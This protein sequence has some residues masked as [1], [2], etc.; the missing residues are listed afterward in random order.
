MNKLWISAG[1]EVQSGKNIQQVKDAIA[2]LV[3]T[4]LTEPGC[5]QFDA[6]QDKETPEHFTLWECWQDEA[7]LKAH[8][9]APHTKAY[10]ANNFTQ[11]RY[12]E[13]LQLTAPNP[14]R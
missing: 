10:I 7:A 3:E 6:L 5:F 1:I 9:E 8:F 11:V 2:K 14:A 4:T 12:V 13:R